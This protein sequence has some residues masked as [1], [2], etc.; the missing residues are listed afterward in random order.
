MGDDVPDLGVMANCG[1]AI[2]SSDACPEARQ[3][4]HY[5]TRALGGFGAVR[6]AIELIL[7]AQGK[8]QPLVDRFL[9]E[10]LEP[11]ETR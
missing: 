5:V 11:V 1:L 9:N 7:N 8:W 6:E 4:A 2:T 3:H 10:K